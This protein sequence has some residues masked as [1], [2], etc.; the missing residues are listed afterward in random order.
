MSD[1]LK[2]LLLAVNQQLKAQRAV[3][4]AA[5]VFFRAESLVSLHWNDYPS[6]NR[7]DRLASALDSAR[8]RQ[9]Q[10]ELELSALWEYLAIGDNKPL[11]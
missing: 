11:P 9:A 8:Q 1:E 4:R 10:A 3:H 6:L 7:L 5:T 2:Q